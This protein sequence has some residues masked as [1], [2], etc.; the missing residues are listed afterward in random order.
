MHVKLAKTQFHTGKLLVTFIPTGGSASNALSQNVLRNIIDLKDCSEFTINLPYLL[1]R[2]YIDV[3]DQ[4][5]QVTIRVLNP[6][7]APD[8]VSSAIEALVYYSAGE[9][10]EVA[11]PVS[12]DGGAVVAQ[13]NVPAK[14]KTVDRIG[15]YV[16][17]PPTMVPVKSCM[18]EAFVSLKQLLTASRPLVRTN[19]LTNI[20]NAPQSSYESLCFW[21]WTMGIPEAPSLPAS[22]LYNLPPMFGDY[23]SEL[24]TGFAYYRGGL[25]YTFPRPLG[26]GNDQT[27]TLIENA[28]FIFS[29]VASTVYPNDDQTLRRI[30]PT[31]LATA[32]GRLRMKAFNGDTTIS[33]DITVPYYGPTP[34]R[35]THIVSG[36]D[37]NIPTTL[38]VNPD[39]LG[40]S[41]VATRAIDY[42]DAG[43][44]RAGADDFQLMYFCGFSG[45]A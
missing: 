39:M 2:S 24:A 14:M 34:F 4:I 8:T 19:V 10:Y 23:V 28:N 5:G 33:G 1:N 27:S 7:V 15:G 38:D 40:I 25:R 6:L 18:G 41:Y 43:C 31:S 44:L 29:K 35:L 13:M 26:V 16:T 12:A 17:E 9:D 42:I 30:N 45:W 20:I 32:P 3:G 21:P 37:P 22:P 11:F 36:I